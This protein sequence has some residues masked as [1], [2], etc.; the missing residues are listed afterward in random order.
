MTDDVLFVCLQPC[1]L[2]VTPQHL[3]W[4]RLESLRLRRLGIPNRYSRHCN[5]VYNNQAAAMNVRF[6]TYLHIVSYLC[7]INNNDDYITQKK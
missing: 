7:I 5:I 3:T 6:N 4:E 2:H 1:H